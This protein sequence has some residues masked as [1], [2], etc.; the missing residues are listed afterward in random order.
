MRGFGV[1]AGLGLGLDFGKGARAGA[2][3]GRCWSTVTT[4]VGVF[5]RNLGRDGF[6]RGGFSGLG[7]FALGAAF[8]LGGRAEVCGTLGFFGGILS[9][10]S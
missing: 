10:V 1:G 9:S 8:C 3:E 5:T 7:G 4:A 2:V 6:L